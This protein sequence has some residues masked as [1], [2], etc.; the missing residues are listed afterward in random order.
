MA[1]IL[2]VDDQRNMRASLGLMLRGAGH[3]VVE[4]ANGEKACELVSGGG[5]DLVLTDLRMQF[6]DGLDVLRHVRRNAP[7]TEVIVMTAFGTVETAVEAMR[8]GAFDYL[9]KPFTEEELLRKVDEALERRW[10]SGEGNMSAESLR[11]KYRFEEIVGSSSQM[12]AV[13]ARVVKISPTDTTVLIT[14]ESGTGKELVAKAI[15]RNSHRA[16][17]P[18]VPVNCAAISEQLLESELFGHVKGSFTGAV[19]TRKGM[20]EEADGGPFFFDEIADTTPSFQ[21]KLLR[22]IQDQ[23][24]RRVG[25]NMGIKVDVRIIA[26]TNR[27]LKEAIA[28]GDF[29]QDLYYRLNVARIR[30]PPLRDRR[31]DI[32][33]LVEHFITKHGKKM[34]KSVRLVEEVQDFLMRYEFPGNV[35]ELE[36]LMEQGVALSADGLL[37]L[38]DILPEA[39]GSSSRSRTLSDVVSEAE[40]VAIQLALREGDSMEQAAERLGLSTTTLWRKM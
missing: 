24:I 4:A 14:G 1:T 18:F 26:A 17:K 30:L 10:L 31:G 32:P 39:T 5:F 35:R 19:T 11:E 20:F 6:L 36:N 37:H 38:D 16:D 28:A 27:N 29:R 22:A 8:I 23:E 2:V 9:E 12:Q 15:Q 21:A 3:E 40:R 25:D 7:L 33:M 34:G 13:L